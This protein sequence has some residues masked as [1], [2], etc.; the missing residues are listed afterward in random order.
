M[1]V[2]SND[3]KNNR[4]KVTSEKAKDPSLKDTH[5]T[6]IESKYAKTIKTANNNVVD[7]NI[8]QQKAAFGNS[9]QN[10]GVGNYNDFF[11]GKSNINN[12]GYTSLGQ[13]SLGSSTPGEPEFIET[14]SPGKKS[15]GAQRLSHNNTS[16]SLTNANTIQNNSVSHN[17]QTGSNS[18]VTNYGL[19]NTGIVE[20]TPSLSSSPMIKNQAHNTIYSRNSS[21]RSSNNEFTRYLQDNHLTINDAKY[22]TG[23]Y[24]AD[25]ETNINNT[26]S[27]LKSQGVVNI[28]SMG[29]KEI[30]HALN[31]GT[32]GNINLGK[33]EGVKTALQE[34]LRLKRDQLDISNIQINNVDTVFTLKQN[35]KVIYQF[36][37]KKGIL[38]PKTLSSKEITEAL[39]SG[40]IGK[41]K[42]D[43]DAQSALKELLDAKKLNK[44]FSASPSQY[45][46]IKRFNDINLRNIKKSDFLKTSSKNIKIGQSFLKNNYKPKFKIGST[47]IKAA[48]TASGLNKAEAISSV[49]KAF[50][51]RN[52]FSKGGLHSIIKTPLLRT[53]V[54]HAATGTA[55]YL[56]AGGSA[57]ALV[58]VGSLHKINI[59]EDN[60]KFLPETA[61]YNVLTEGID[62][63]EDTGFQQ[64]LNYAG[65]FQ[66][67][68]QKNLRHFDPESK[69]SGVGLP[70]LSK[71]FLDPHD[72]SIIERL[73][74]TESKGWFLLDQQGY[75]DSL[76][77]KNV[78]N[79]E[80]LNPIMREESKTAYYNKSENTVGKYDNVKDSWVKGVD[81]KG[82]AVF[83][84]EES[85]IGYDIDYYWG[86]KMFPYEYSFDF[87]PT[88]PQIEVPEGSGH[89]VDDKSGDPLVWGQKGKCKLYGTAGLR[90]DASNDES[91]I[92]LEGWKCVG[93]EDGYFIYEPKYIKTYTGKGG[94]A[95]TGSSG[96]REY[97]VEET[98]AYDNRLANDKYRMW[99]KLDGQPYTTYKGC[100]TSE[101]HDYNYL[102]SG[103]TKYK[104]DT[105]KYNDLYNGPGFNDEVG[106]YKSTEYKIGMYNLVEGDNPGSDYS[107]QFD[108]NNKNNELYD[109]EGAGV[110]YEYGSKDFYNNIGAIFHSM[111]EG[112]E[113]CVAFEKNF[114]A[115]Q[116]WYQASRA[117]NKLDTFIPG[118]EGDEDRSPSVHYNEDDKVWAFFEHFPEEG[119]PTAGPKD[120]PMKGTC[121][122]TYKAVG[123]LNTTYLDIGIQDMM[124][125]DD[126]KDE[127]CHRAENHVYDN[128]DEI[129]Y[130]AVWL[131]DI[132]E[133]DYVLEG[134]GGSTNPG[135]IDLDSYK[136]DADFEEFKDYVEY[137]EEH[138]EEVITYPDDIAAP[139]ELISLPELQNLNNAELINALLAAGY[140]QQKAEAMAACYNALTNAGYSPNFAV[141]FMANINHEGAL[142]MVQG[143]YQV[144]TNVDDLLVFK[145][146]HGSDRGYAFGMCQW[147]GGR[148]T[149]LLDLYIAQAQANGGTITK[150]QMQQIECGY[151]LSELSSYE[152]KCVGKINAC[153]NVYDA[154]MACQKWFERP[155]KVNS[156]RG[157]TA[158]NIATIIKNM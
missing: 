118:K 6:D 138:P 143:T 103:K 122:H 8:P 53:G 149:A 125:V 98:K 88:W 81:K 110:M 113:E 148:K 123:W 37:E 86:P 135:Y 45:G 24:L 91:I 16:D 51:L 100:V 132:Y 97:I 151:L 145:R 59:L 155:K 36:L 35:E 56:A 22:N 107:V 95:Y 158:N 5:S 52:L 92:Y 75:Y 29:V 93:K 142:G 10:G 76:A 137:K 154:A 131:K 42:L 120:G 147:D 31:T 43:K 65:F 18:G 60:I 27:F 121:E 112:G 90:G 109:I 94:H 21:I 3:K 85:I 83:E 9:L 79:D 108:R 84:D 72:H 66:K 67:A 54:S 102:N 140:S 17:Q 152:N 116:Y 126:T 63:V 153:T 111:T 25:L 124:R 77:V 50:H 129:S 48:K 139:S 115:K 41:I 99:N 89:W 32:I 26:S 105:D 11:G 136:G 133:E 23:H 4:I 57:L 28:N 55:G 38:N 71:S 70:G 62:K 74:T 157:E 128:N 141:A 58:I 104:I 39:E 19:Q 7:N 78:K 30:E 106:E 150:A 47:P 44:S 117:I 2:V 20:E 64:S 15:Y 119:V 80:F 130:K 127:Y 134:H 33:N 146:N 87:G 114:Y 82:K 46:S 12:T 101:L 156:K 61:I 73:K 13:E 144:L 14:E 34:M 96:K 49:K 1:P 40:Q 68:S 69:E